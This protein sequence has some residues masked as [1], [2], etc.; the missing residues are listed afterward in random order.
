MA[1]LVVGAVTV[2]VA[3]SESDEDRRPVGG[4]IVQ[5]FDG[6]SRSTVRGYKRTLFIV[7]RLLNSSDATTLLAALLTTTLPVSCS[8]DLLGGTVNCIPRLKKNTGV[9]AG[10]SLRRRISFD[11]VEA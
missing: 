6:S 2:K 10:A 11:L 7:T 5:M 1:T 9:R 4:E 8:G 3:A